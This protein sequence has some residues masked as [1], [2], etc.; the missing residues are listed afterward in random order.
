MSSVNQ[1][2]VG[3]VLIGGRAPVSIQTMWDKHVPAVDD[4]LIKTL[5]SYEKKGC[6]LIRFALPS[7]HDVDIIAGIIPRI[8]MPLV[9][10]IHFD[11]KIALKAIEKGFHKIRI[12]PGNIGADWKVREII[13]AAAD[14]GTAIRIGAN[15]GSLSAE[16]K[17]VARDDTASERSRALV[18]AAE[19]NL[20]L[21]EQAGFKNI[22][23]S[24]KSSDIHVTYHSN[25]LFRQHHAYP[26]HLG[27]TEAGPLIP[28]IVKST[29]G[30]SDLLKEGIGETV[31]ISIS[32]NPE[33]E[34]LTGVELLQNLG[35]RKGRIQI[36]SCP[37]CGRSS[38]DTHA[39]LESVKEELYTMPLD[40]TVAIM[41]CTVNG[42]GEA[43]HAD[44][45]ITG[46]GKKIQIFR[47]GKIIRREDACSAKKAFLEELHRLQ[48]E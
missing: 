14:H 5:E 9:G 34:V 47:H 3:S 31:R 7:L 37:K 19:S 39:F 23:I 46:F 11:Y 43:S 44:L 42:P 38:F 8:T 1:V 4:Q 28:A 2:K 45:G 6:N 20:D 26:L 36:V 17:K 24:L 21:F 15:E 27:I 48:Q 33:Y 35:L 18:A 41:G 22:V 10:D 30:L 16:Q 13:H 32:D 29:I 12:N 40:A 25:K